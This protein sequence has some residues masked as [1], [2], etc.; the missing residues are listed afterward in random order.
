MR[1]GVAALV[2]ALALS[3]CT[4]DPDRP[5]ELTPTPP[6]S[7][8]ASPSA[9]GVE[10]PKELAVVGHATLPQLRLSRAAADRLLQGGAERWRGFRVVRG[11]GAVRAVE[12]DP[13]ALGVVPLD[14]VGPTVVAAMVGGSDP[15]RNR[16]E[17]TQLTV[18]GDLML[19]RRVPDP[20]TALAGMAARLRS[21]DLTVGNL[22]STLS[23]RGEPTQ[24]DF[25]GG[26]AALIEPL[27]RAGLD[28]LS[29]ANNHVGD[30]GE[31][32][33]LDTV[34]QLRSSPITPFGAGRDDTE[35][36]RPAVLEANGTT[37]AFLGFNAIGETPRAEPGQPG[38]LSVRMPPRTGP[39]V[40][41]DLGRVND[42]IRQAS[43]EADVVVVMPH[44]GEQYTH[45]PEPVQRLVSRE[46]VRAGADL[47]VGGHP[48]WVQGVDEV[49]GV[50][51]AHS[52]G[53]FVFD[54]DF[55]TETME[56]VVLEATFWGATLKALR[57][58]PYRMDPVT[59]APGVVGGAAGAEVL[60]DLW[61]SSTGPFARR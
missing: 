26:S 34:R 15:I 6:P 14:R 48:H 49:R 23:T 56:G 16:R 43:R 7:V 28:A 11:A 38:A 51:V 45:T 27:R 1:R 40:R 12:R 30:Y 57:L 41:S 9:T 17:S 21:A 3:S 31:L 33:L 35:A 22:E 36:A 55:M 59:F 60:D 25:F 58:V 18:V 53:N 42:A 24:D 5:Q 8:A 39:L 61:T 32:A 4:S 29:L 44:W 10:E 37:F 52:L 50:P 2:V 19:V 20:W 46:L 13:G 54:M 47:V